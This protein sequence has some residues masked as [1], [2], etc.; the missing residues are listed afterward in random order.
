[1]SDRKGPN[2]RLERVITRDERVPLSVDDPEMQNGWHSIPMP[3]TH[4]EGWF[5]LEVR[6]YKTVWGRWVE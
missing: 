1:M 4:D 3:P 2:K 5:V 6:D